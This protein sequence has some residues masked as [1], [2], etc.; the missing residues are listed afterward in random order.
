MT[1][2]SQPESDSSRFL[3]LLHQ[4]EVRE[5]AFLK[6]IPDIVI[7]FDAAGKCLFFYP[8]SAVQWPFPYNDLTG[9][10]LR[11]CLSPDLVE[12]LHVAA[13]KTR[14]SGR[15][16]HFDFDLDVSLGRT[17]SFQARV[18]AGAEDETYA[19]FREVTEMREM[20]HSLQSAEARYRSL[21]EN[22]PQDFF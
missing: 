3:A 11:H 5:S 14:L 20:L 19:F 8:G 10:N 17:R 4:L 22:L 13:K 15:T 7:A 18:V 9:R 16:E 6:A 21:I 2:S 1:L 12:R